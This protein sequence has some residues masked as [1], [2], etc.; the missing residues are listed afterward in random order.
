MSVSESR[1]E[2][3]DWAI[4]VSGR[5]VSLRTRMGTFNYPSSKFGEDVG[6]WTSLVLAGLV[7]SGS[8]RLRLN[9]PNRYRYKWIFDPIVERFPAL[10]SR[11]KQDYYSLLLITEDLVLA[12]RPGPASIGTI[13]RIV[14]HVEE[15][16]EISKTRSAPVFD[17]DPDRELITARLLLSYGYYGRTQN[18]TV[19]EENPYT[20]LKSRFTL[21]SAIFT[22]ELIRRYSQSW[23]LLPVVHVSL[24]TGRR[25]ERLHVSFLERILVSMMT[26][27]LTDT[28][29]RKLQTGQLKT[30]VL[31]AHVEEDRVSLAVST[32]LA[33]GEPVVLVYRTHEFLGA[34]NKLADAISRREP[35]TRIEKMILRSDARDNVINMIDYL[36][37][38]EDDHATVLNEDWEPVGQYTTMRKLVEKLVELTGDPKETVMRLCEE[39]ERLAKYAPVLAEKTGGG[40]ECPVLDKIVMRLDG[41]TLIGKIGRRYYRI[42]FQ[43]PPLVDAKTGRTLW[44]VTPVSILL[45]Q[46]ST[47]ELKEARTIIELVLNTTGSFSSE[48]SGCVHATF[49]SYL[50]VVFLARCKTKSGLEWAR[51]K[52]KKLLGSDTKK[53]P[54]E[55]ARLLGQVLDQY[56]W[57]GDKRRDRNGNTLIEYRKKDVIVLLSPKRL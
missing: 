48:R 34:M 28:L 20:Y 12:E 5:T 6:A 11:R 13:N 1:V 31:E 7:L 57:E 55:Y 40:R 36:V 30:R 38:L 8:V 53:I 39:R 10:R 17:D 9:Y 21:L 46:M 3:R 54:P 56:G 4:T 26:G 44:D 45:E 23:R 37:L 2:R 15:G 16:W 47:P 19:Y 43:R 27:K 49:H 14:K 18:R 41:K 33:R 42:S 25:R 24:G 29:N 22:E 51:K 50:G 35:E 52:A 32:S